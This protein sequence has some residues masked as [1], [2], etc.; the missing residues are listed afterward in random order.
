MS[1]GEGTP[2]QFDN[3]GGG[4][5]KQKARNKTKAKGEWRLLS[6]GGGLFRQGMETYRANAR[7]E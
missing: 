1:H 6:T 7:C 5:E 4:E 3:K 2:R